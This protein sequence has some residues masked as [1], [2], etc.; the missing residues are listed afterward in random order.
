MRYTSYKTLCRLRSKKPTI[1][2][3]PPARMKQTA[4]SCTMGG[5]VLQ[6]CSNS[7]LSK[8]RCDT[9]RVLSTFRSG[10]SS[11][12]RGVLSE[13]TKHQLHFPIMR[14]NRQLHI[15][16]LLFALLVSS[17]SHLDSLVAAE[18]DS[19]EHC[20]AVKADKGTVLIVGC[21]HPE[22]KHILKADS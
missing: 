5:S 16:C 1:F 17:K 18:L 8:R 19:V 11:N 10:Y 22:T 21:L 9:H 7:K 6:L 15:M 20:M 13:E 3:G 14:V 4:R 12:T 2:A